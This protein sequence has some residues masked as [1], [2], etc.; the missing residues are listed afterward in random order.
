MTP[1]STRARKARGKRQTGILGDG[2]FIH[3]QINLAGSI[4]SR[5]LEVL[6]QVEEHCQLRYG[7]PPGKNEG[8]TLC[9]AKFFAELE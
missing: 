2:R 9:L 7:V 6:E 5:Q 3:R 8:V 4:A 1:L